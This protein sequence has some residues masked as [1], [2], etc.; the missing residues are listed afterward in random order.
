MLAVYTYTG[1]KLRVKRFDGSSWGTEKTGTSN[2]VNAYSLSAASEGDDV[3][4]VFCKAST[5]YILHVKYTYS[6]DSLGSETTLDTGQSNTSLPVI[7]RDDG[8]GHLYVFWAL[9]N[10]VY[11]RKHNGSSWED[12]VDWISET[13]TA[14]YNVGCFEK[15]YGNYVGILYTGG[16][17]SPYNV[18]FAFLSVGAVSHMRTHNF[19][20]TTIVIT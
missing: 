20:T 16:S 13:L 10:H 19:G 5:Y 4:I 9:S 14:N 11:Y 6:A 1:T 2:V 18:K 17:S 15:R 8:L 12:E 3:H 7:C